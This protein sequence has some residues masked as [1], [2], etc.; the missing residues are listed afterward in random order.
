[1]HNDEQSGRPS[2]DE[3]VSKVDEVKE[4]HQ[5]TISELSLS[6]PQIWWLAGQANPYRRRD[7]SKKRELQ[8]HITVYEVDKRTQRGTAGECDYLVEISGGRIL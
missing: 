4:D 5:F 3:I 8:N 2:I 6:F 1:M 7:L